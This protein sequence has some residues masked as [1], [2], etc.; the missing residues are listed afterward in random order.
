[1]TREE[2]RILHE[3]NG[4][5]LYADALKLIRDDAA[6]RDI[7]QDVFKALLANPSLNPKD[8]KAYVSTAVRN[9][10][11][12]WKARASRECE[13]LPENEPVWVAPP[14]FEALHASVEAALPKLTFEHQEIIQ[15]SFYQKLNKSQIAER[16]GLPLSTVESR[17]RHALEKLEPMLAS[18]VKEDRS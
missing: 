18:S 1:M 6:A 15:L 5:Y 13:L 16:L 7:V 3:T 9:G 10:V 8:P 12:H 11:L 17:L 4:D 2:V 14:E